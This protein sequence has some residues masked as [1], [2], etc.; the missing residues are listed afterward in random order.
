M[1]SLTELVSLITRYKRRQIEILSYNEDSTNKYEVF[2]ERIE[3]G[4]LENDDEAAAFFFG[5]DK[6]GKFT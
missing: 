6:G 2:Y 4:K 5:P 1:R 3:N